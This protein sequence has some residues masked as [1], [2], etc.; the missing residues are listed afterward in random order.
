MARPQH[1]GARH[2]KKQVS[3]PKEKKLEFVQD[4]IPLKEIKNGIVETNDGRYIKILEIEPINFLLRSSEEQ[5]GIIS[6]F[7]SWLK[8]SPMRL[9]FKSVT[10]RADSDKYIA[11]LKEDLKQEEVA[12]CRTLGEGTI[13]FIREEGS[14]EALSRRFFLI[15]QYEAAS[16]RQV[17]AEYGEIYAALQTAAQNARTY[18][19]Q[20]GNSIVQP[21]DEDAFTAE[22]LYMLLQEE[23][24]IIHWLTQ[25]GALTK[26]QV[27]RLLKDKTPQTAEKIIR[28]LKR[29][30]LLHDI[31]G[32]Y[33]LGV[34]PMCQPEQ[35]IILSV[36][37]LLQFID[38]VEP[39]A[40][41]PATY[42]SQ[43]FFLKENMGYEIVVLYDGEQHL[44]RLLQPQEDL[45][46]I[47][48]LPRI[49]MAQELVLPN[50]P[51]LFATV[52]YNGQEVPTVKFYTEEG[53]VSNGAD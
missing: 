21:K 52:D 38:H 4:F 5:W 44:A 3:P 37:V 34:D 35:R 31:A 48:V 9:Q 6:T 14:R 51:C 39:M 47:F 27:I 15:F 26:T 17:D 30:V 43:I 49:S 32:G 12:A 29:E 19:A 24:Y 18:F 41:Y 1:K 50:V 10:R 22:V 36:W 53:G 11:G 16:R 8:I 28:G 13:R 45:R 20:C 7:A 2:P 46:Y 25:Y 42:P 40:H 23:Q 33:Y